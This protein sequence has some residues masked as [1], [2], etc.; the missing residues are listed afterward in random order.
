M[1]SIV[2]KEIS[3]NAQPHSKRS[4]WILSVGL[5][6]VR[7]VQGWIYWGGGSRRFIYGP[8][9]LNPHDHWMAYK[10]QT[11]MPGAILGTQHIIAFL[12]H[13][14]TLL[15]AC[16][17]IFSAVELVSGLMLLTGFLTRLAA[18]L[19]LGLSFT[20]MLMFGWQGATC[21]DEWTMAA[22]NFAMGITLVLLGSGAYSLDNWV[23]RKNPVLAE[24]GWFRWLGGSTPLPLSDGAFKKLSLVLFWIGVVFIVGTYSY[25][26]GSVVTPFHGDPTGVKAH[27]IALTKGRIVDHKTLDVTMYVDAGTPTVPAHIIWIRLENAAGKTLDRWNAK[28]LSHLNPKAIHNIFAYQKVAP[29]PLLGLEAGLAAKATLELPLVRP[30]NNPSANSHDKIVMQGING[31]VSTGMVS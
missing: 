25:Y 5:L 28:T 21:I 30:L 2:D 22:S 19:T 27:H 11:A 23:A 14:F 12:L 26:R 9:K 31:V 18:F 16:V 24:K 8:Q 20:L 15:Y 3:K 10:F 29:D 17:I 4:W 13:H 7:F 1:T 6:A